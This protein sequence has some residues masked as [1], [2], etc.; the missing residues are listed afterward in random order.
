LQVQATDTL[1]GQIVA[2]LKRVG[3]YDDSLVIVT[4]DHGVA[5]TN[6]EPTRS[7]TLRNY[8][9]I[10]WPPLFIKYPGQRTGRID[11]RPAQSIDI[12][13]TIAEVIGMKIPWPVDGTSLLRPVRP[14]MPRRMY[15][16]PLPGRRRTEVTPPPGQNYF[17]FDGRLGFSHVL[18]ARAA[19]AGGDP[20]LRLYRLGRY[21]SLV[22]QRARPLVAG[23]AGPAI[24]EI[25]NLSRFDHVDPSARGIPWFQSY[26]FVGRLDRSG[27]IAVALD[28]TIVAVT[29]TGVLNRAGTRPFEFLAP[30]TLVHA[31]K[32]EVSVYLVRGTAGVPRLASIRLRTRP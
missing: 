25:R 12:L 26:G 16:A 23:G 30:P 4:A 3:A 20:Q 13:P 32:N 2:R 31:G 15:E 27:W 17:T 28:G 1:L 11:D 14:D 29:P 7:A 18:A 19:P 10:M 5:F 24:A 6:G 22:G 21:G 8:P 9:E